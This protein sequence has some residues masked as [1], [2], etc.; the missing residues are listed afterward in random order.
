MT[1]SRIDNV[2]KKLEMV[3]NTEQELEIWT[4]LQC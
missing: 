1:D 3:E 4:F 2:R